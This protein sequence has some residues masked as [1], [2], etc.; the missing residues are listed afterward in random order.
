MRHLLMNTNTILE[1][2]S[3]YII[4][5]IISI[6]YLISGIITFKI[7]EKKSRKKGFQGF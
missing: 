5:T 6:V 4:L 2:N 1:I 7:L 3:E